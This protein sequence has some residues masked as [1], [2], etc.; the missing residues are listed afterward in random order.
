MTATH[1]GFAR[2]ATSR[3]ACSGGETVSRAV[4]VNA[5]TGE[6]QDMAV[7]DVPQWVDHVYPRTSSFSSTTGMASTPMAG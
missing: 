3:L 6:C 5:A 2:C 1:G 4:L 7:E